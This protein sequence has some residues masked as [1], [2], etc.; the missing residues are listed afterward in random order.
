MARAVFTNANWDQ[1][2]GL[3]DGY[4]PPY[5]WLLPIVAGALSSRKNITGQGSAT[6]SMAGG[7]NA[8]AALSGA[9]DMSATGALIVSLVASLS[10]S[11]D[12]TSASAIAFL[13]LAASLAGSGDLSG[14]VTA[15]AHAS[16][17]V[18]GTGN[19]SSTASALGTLAASIVVTGELLNTANVAPAVWNAIAAS[20]NAA[21]S[22]GNKLNSAASG[23]VDYEALAAAVIAALN[24]TAIPVDAVKM[25]GA[26][27]LGS[28]TE[29][30][31]WRGGV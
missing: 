16:A 1:L 30:D 4:R 23:G 19:V 24:A 6:I 3:P 21:G 29:S 18:A 11:G 25:N 22:M 13:N 14:A 28:G 31:K 7:L 27:I 2:S 5:A 26:D 12:I 15:I 9:G 20:F 8:E 10:G 17:E